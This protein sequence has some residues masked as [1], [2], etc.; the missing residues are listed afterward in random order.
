MRS[1]RHILI[2]N[3]RKVQQPVFIIGAPHS[4]T[5]L[6]AR[7]L[8]RADGVHLTIGQSSVLRVIYAFAR[9][10]S[11]HDGRGEAAASVLRDAFGQG[12]R[13]TAHG[14]LECVPECRE[15]AGL[16]TGTGPCATERGLQLYGDASPDL[17]YCAE[18]LTDAF[19][20]A[21]I[22]QFIRDGRDVVACMLRDPAILS[23]FKPSFAN[24]DTEFPNPFFGVETEEDRDGWRG[25]VDGRQVRDALAGGGPAG[26]PAAAQP[27]RGAAHH[28]ALRD[29]DRAARRDRVG[30]F[31]VRRHGAAGRRRCAKL[32]DAPSITAGGWR[33]ALSP[34]QAA[35]VEK[36]AGEELRRV[37]YALIQRPRKPTA[38][39]GPK[40]RPPA[41]RALAA[42]R[43][44]VLS[45][46]TTRR[47]RRSARYR[48]SEPGLVPGEWPMCRRVTAAG[49][50]AQRG[51]RGVVPPG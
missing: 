28:G 44:T 45:A 18:A 22:V 10:P 3:G 23:W 13:I 8:K 41:S 4:G 17:A 2:V 33:R 11:I 5:H 43:V 34:D 26:R 49:R 24:L 16:G 47:L 15:A 12:W 36:V 50:G 46:S 37:G 32:R 35:D 6:L 1:A 9:R 31:R 42:R 29:A 21:R 25:P 48:P 19:P 30:D 7:A 40:V 20:D 38:S 39:G 51:V 14:C 27:A